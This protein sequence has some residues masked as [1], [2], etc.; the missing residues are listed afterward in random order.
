MCAYVY[1]WACVYVCVYMRVCVH[2]DMSVCVGV[3]IPVIG[4]FWAKMWN[5]FNKY[6]F[7]Y[8]LLKLLLWL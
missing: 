6:Y 5:L 2:V 7:S 8:M 3:C 4:L 1:V